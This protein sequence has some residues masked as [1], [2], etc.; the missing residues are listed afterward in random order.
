MFEV[1]KEGTQPYKDQG[2]ELQ[3]EEIIIE[4]QN[5]E[6]KKTKTEGLTI[7]CL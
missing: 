3:A 5:Q 4:W 7:F 6:K 1:R 2:R